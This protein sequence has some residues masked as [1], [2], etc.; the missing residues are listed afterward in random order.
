[1]RHLTEN[2]TFVSFKLQIN[3]LRALYRSL[4]NKHLC[5][6]PL[7]SVLYCLI[8]VFLILGLIGVD[9][10]VLLG[11]SYPVS[12]SFRPRDMRWKFQQ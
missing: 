9:I 8:L 7:I 12:Y 4:L 5:F 3:V 1:M 6:P 10:S 11:I 2:W